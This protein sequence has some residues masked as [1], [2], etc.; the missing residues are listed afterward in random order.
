MPVE[1][2]SKSGKNRCWTAVH[3]KIKV[4]ETG[5]RSHSMRGNSHDLSSMAAK[6]GVGEVSK[7]PERLDGIRHPLLE[8]FSIAFYLWH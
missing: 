3:G 8:S 4:K 6:Y 5:A 7:V 2:V 1:I